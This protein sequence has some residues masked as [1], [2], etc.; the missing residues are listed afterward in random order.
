MEITSRDD[1]LMDAGKRYR[2]DAERIQAPGV[3]AQVNGNHYSVHPSLK[4]SR[5]HHGWAPVTICSDISIGPSCAFAAFF[6]ICLEG[7]VTGWD[8]R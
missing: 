4:S 7:A 3:Q 1:V 5:G 8:R 2:A 6:H